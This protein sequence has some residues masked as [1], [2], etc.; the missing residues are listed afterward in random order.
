MTWIPIWTTAN[1]IL[2][3]PLVIPSLSYGLFAFVAYGGH[4]KEVSQSLESEKKEMN[5][6]S[7]SLCDPTSPNHR[8]PLANYNP[9]IFRKN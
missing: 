2:I 7:Q 4:N 5:L 6:W 9:F 3:Y 8:S 1:K